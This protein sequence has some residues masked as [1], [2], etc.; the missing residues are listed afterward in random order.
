MTGALMREQARK[1]DFCQPP[2]IV[3][4]TLEEYGIYGTNVFC[5][6]VTK[7]KNKQLLDCKHSFLAWLCQAHPSH[8]SHLS[9]IPWRFKK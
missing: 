3:G 6:L 8:R 1:E 2:L 5:N 7:Q 9:H 4:I